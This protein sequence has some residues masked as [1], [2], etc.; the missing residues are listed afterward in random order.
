MKFIIVETRKRVSLSYNKD[1]KDIL[2]DVCDMKPFVEYS[3]DNGAF[4]IHKDDFAFWK[5]YVEDC[6]MIDKIIS[7]LRNTY[8]ER[9]DK[10]L[11]GTQE[12]DHWS[13][14]EVIMDSLKDE[15]SAYF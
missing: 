15:L 10:A 4:L 9:I 12:Y 11:E 13:R 7:D 5:G 3:K 2:F 8:G 1:G 6:Q 14:L